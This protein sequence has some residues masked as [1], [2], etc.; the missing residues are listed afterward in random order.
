MPQQ[1]GLAGLSRAGDEHSGKLLRHAPNTPFNFLR[2]P[3][4]DN[5][6]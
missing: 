6:H 1:R 2:N 5:M 4:A 3:H